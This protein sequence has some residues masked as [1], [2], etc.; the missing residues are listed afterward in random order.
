MRCLQPRV[1]EGCFLSESTQPRQPSPNVST[2]TAASGQLAQTTDSSKIDVKAVNHTMRYGSRRPRAC[3]T[4]ECCLADRS[5][6]TPRIP[7]A[8]L[9][10][11][12][13]FSSM[14]VFGASPELRAC[15]L[16]VL[17]LA[18]HDLRAARGDHCGMVAQACRE[19]NGKGVVTVRTRNAESDLEGVQHELCNHWK[20]TQRAWRT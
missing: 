18:K 4:T 7:Q 20:D 19:T 14:I 13:G 17:W 10:T 11:H 9:Q 2:Q 5:D 16:H 1:L 8:F 15:A 6:T 3:R 12:Q